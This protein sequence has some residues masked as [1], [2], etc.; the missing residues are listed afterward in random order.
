MFLSK[1]L[2]GCGGGAGFSVFPVPFSRA[3]LVALVQWLQGCP[4]GTSPVDIK[5]SLELAE[6]GDK[7]LLPALLHDSVALASLKLTVDTLPEAYAWSVMFSDSPGDLGGAARTLRAAVVEH[8]GR[9]EFAKELWNR[10]V[11]EGGGLSNTTGG[12]HPLVPPLALSSPH[13]LTHFSDIVAFFLK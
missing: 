11:R 4:L 5:C 13:Y 1:I 9:P 7:L 10:G 6:I 3:P 2:G 12:K 8:F